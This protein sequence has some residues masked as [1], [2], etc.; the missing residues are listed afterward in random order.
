ME[1]TTLYLNMAD[2]EGPGGRDYKY[3]GRWNSSGTSCLTEL[4]CL[5]LEI[6]Q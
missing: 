3:F 5:L 1:D 4:R 6:F 2:F